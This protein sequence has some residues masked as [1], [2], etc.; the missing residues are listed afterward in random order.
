MNAV[1]LTHTDNDGGGNY[2]SNAGTIQTV[3]SFVS[4]AGT[5]LQTRSTSPTGIS[6]A[7]CSTERTSR[8]YITTKARFDK[9]IYYQ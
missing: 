8:K 3:E 9:E 7:A 2:C 1:F 4:S 6:C 5:N